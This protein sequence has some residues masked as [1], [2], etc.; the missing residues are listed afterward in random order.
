MS[1]D[2]Y[3]TTNIQELYTI[4]LYM[5]NVKNE[6]DHKIFKLSLNDK[7]SILYIDSRYD[8]NKYKEYVIKGRVIKIYQQR[9]T[10]RYCPGC[11][12]ECPWYNIIID[13]STEY[14]KDIKTISSKNILDIHYLPYDYELETPPEFPDPL[15]KYLLVNEIQ[16]N[17]I[18]DVTA[19]NDAALGDKDY[20]AEDIRVDI[21]SGGVL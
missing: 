13:C 17:I 12:G 3:K 16:D 21:D 4:L 14:S 7:V 15:T 18:I 6:K 8:I 11:S 10:N 2:K 19:P 1:L 9:D 5:V 20:D